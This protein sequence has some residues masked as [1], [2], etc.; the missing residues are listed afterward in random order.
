MPTVSELLPPARFKHMPTERSE[1]VSVGMRIAV[2]PAV[3]GPHVMLMDAVEDA[4]APEDVTPAIQT[5]SVLLPPA[6]VKHLPAAG[7]AAS[8]NS[9]VDGVPASRGPHGMVGGVLEQVTPANGVS[10]E[11]A[12]RANRAGITGWIESCPKHAVATVSELLP[13]SRV[14]HI[15][16]AGS[17]SASAGASLVVAPASGEPHAVASRVSKEAPPVVQTVSELLPPARVKHVP[18]EGSA[19]ASA[20]SPADR[21]PASRGPRVG[22]NVSTAGR[23]SEDWCG[24]QPSNRVSVELAG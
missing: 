23:G 2:V 21:A 20:G 9:P 3:R 13:P 17:A 16:I 24:G 1:T 15:P 18:A 10:V 4:L 14:K 5:I 11:S 8:A 6:R 12:G 7:T 19:A 22:G